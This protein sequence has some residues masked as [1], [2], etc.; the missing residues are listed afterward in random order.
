MP[1][2]QINNYIIKVNKIKDSIKLKVS[3]NSKIYTSIFIDNQNDTSANTNCENNVTLSLNTDIY[4]FIINCL[5]QKDNY[6]Y[7]IV[8]EDE[9]I[10]IYFTFKYEMFDFNYIIGLDLK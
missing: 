2:Y 8:D 5:D 4:D 10:K 9:H 3:N 6:N 7:Q 1:E